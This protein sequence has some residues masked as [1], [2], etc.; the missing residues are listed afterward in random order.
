MISS[1]ECPGGTVSEHL[2]FLSRGLVVPVGAFEAALAIERAGHR[3]HLD[4]SDL[5]IEPAGDVD[6]DDLANL[7]RWKPHV[8]MLLAYTPDERHL[9]DG[10][11]APPVPGPNVRRAS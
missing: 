6:P 7:R 5:F 10:H 2:V 11:V 4:G 8:R 9:H 1:I 3:L